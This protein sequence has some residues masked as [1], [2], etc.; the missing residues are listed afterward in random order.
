MT[1][2]TISDKRDRGVHLHSPAEQQTPQA[3]RARIQAAVEL[4]QS[5]IDRLH[6]LQHAADRRDETA[7]RVRSDNAALVRTAQNRAL[8]REALRSQTLSV[9]KKWFLGFVSEVLGDRRMLA[10]TA[11]SLAESDIEHRRIATLKN[12]LE[13]IRVQNGLAPEEVQ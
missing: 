7:R 3:G 1:L 13:K 2:A 4:L 5:E 6:A 10:D 8:A 9:D 11:S 12:A